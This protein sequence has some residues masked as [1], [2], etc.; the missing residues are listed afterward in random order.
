MNTLSDIV[1]NI[2]RIPQLREQRPLGW[3]LSHPLPVRSAGK[4]AWRC[5]LYPSPAIRD[6]PRPVGRPRALLTVSGDGSKLLEYLDLSVRDVFP[7]IE[8]LDPKQIGQATRELWDAIGTLGAQDVDAEPDP[9]ARR[10]VLAARTGVLEPG[11]LPFYDAL[12][13]EFWSWL[14]A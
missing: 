5:F 3:R 1:R 12:C 13:P 2:S 7:A 14:G 11:L 10:V 8:S 6:R 4:L 9:Q